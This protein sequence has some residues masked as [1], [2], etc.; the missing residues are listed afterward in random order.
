[1][2]TA[3][4]TGAA[5]VCVAVLAAR[6]STDED[7][8][9]ADLHFPVFAPVLDG[10]K[11]RQIKFPEITDFTAVTGQGVRGAL[12]GVVVA[13]GNAELMHATG[14]EPAALARRAD[15]LRRDAKTVMFLARDGQ[16][17]GLIAVQDPIKRDATRILAALHDEKLRIVMLTG[18]NEAT[19]QAVAEQLRIDEVHAG[20]TPATKADWIARAKASGARVAMAGDGVNDAPAL[21]SADVGIAMGNGSDVAKESATLQAL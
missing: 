13:L 15:E 9:L 19:A 17:A 11:A 14:A 1:M 12:A 3:R 2:S 4:V 21:A 18:D 6:C 16:L 10:A 20:Q 5:L 7:A 8:D